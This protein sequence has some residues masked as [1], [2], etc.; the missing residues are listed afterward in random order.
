MTK[1]TKITLSSFCLTGMLCATMASAQVDQAAV[2]ADL[3]SINNISTQ[4][5]NALTKEANAKP[6]DTEALAEAQKRS[7]AISGLAEQAKSLAATMLSQLANGNEDAAQAT[8]D[9]IKATVGK[10]KDAL[11][12]V[13][14]QEVMDVANSKGESV[15]GPGFPFDPPN[16]Y[17]VPWQSQEMQAFYQNYFGTLWMSGVNPPDLEATPE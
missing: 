7:E 9:E 16:M 15:S 2:A 1:L 5:S 3:G 13:I 14:P 12:G 6:V 11:Q 10:A 4:A 8:A 17:D